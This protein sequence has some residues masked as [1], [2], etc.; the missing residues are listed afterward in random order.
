MR[1]QINF[2]KDKLIF[3]IKYI[4]EMKQYGL[5]GKRLSH[6]FSKKYFEEKFNKLSLKNNSY[7]LFELSAIS[8]F[9]ALV[10]S[11]PDL[12]GLNVTIP[13]KETVLAFLDE[14]DE[15]AMQIGAVNC[16][17]I[18]RTNGNTHLKGYN[19]DAFGFQQSIKPFLEPQ[20][21]R[22]LILGNGGSAKAVAYVLNKIG[23]PTWNVTRVKIEGIANQFTYE[24]LNFDL[25]KHFKLIINCTPVGMSPASDVSPALPYEA[26]ESDFLLYDLIYNPEET[27]FIKQGKS[28]SAVCINGLSMLYHQADEAWRIW[29][30]L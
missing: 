14:F 8:D 30:R 4:C 24:E 22:A 28:R 11:H 20:H 13:Y 29:N 17:K 1:R 5:I 15:S 18:T 3:E 27:L 19:T 9:P 21:E 23:I 7:D 10:K 16:I 6:S 25:L 26:I 12:L 2:D